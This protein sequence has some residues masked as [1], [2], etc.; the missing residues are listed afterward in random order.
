M[1]RKNI[2][3]LFCAPPH[4]SNTLQWVKQ[5]KHASFNVVHLP[6]SDAARAR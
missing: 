2:I 1:T 6:L 4:G 3:F 5:A